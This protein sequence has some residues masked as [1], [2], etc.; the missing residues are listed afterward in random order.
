MKGTIFLDIE[1]HSPVNHIT[2]SKEHTKKAVPGLQYCMIEQ[3]S[4]QHALPSL[5]G[6]KSK[7]RNRQPAVLHKHATCFVLV[8][9]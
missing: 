8:S 5:S 6:L 4:T 7:S 3:K 9:S 2:V 1:M